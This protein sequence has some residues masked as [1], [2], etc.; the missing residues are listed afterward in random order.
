MNG[1]ILYR[2]IHESPNTGQGML[3]KLVSPTPSH[4]IG[5]ASGFQYGWG[6]WSNSGLG[7]DTWRRGIPAP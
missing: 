2:T 6:S 7:S 5:L 4:S 1:L 3:E